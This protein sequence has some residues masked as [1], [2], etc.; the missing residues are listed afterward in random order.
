MLTAAGLAWD[1][2]PGL[3]GLLLS[4]ALIGAGT[5]VITPLG[6]AALAASTPAARLG[7]T[8][9]AAEPPLDHVGDRPG[10]LLLAAAIATVAGL[11]YGYAAHSPCSSPP[12]HSS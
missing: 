8:M 12:P 10:G 2:L 5:G 6:F 11:A 7:Q 1:V 9:G 3:P 4:A